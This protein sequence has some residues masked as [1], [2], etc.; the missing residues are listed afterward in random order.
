V[1]G[2]VNFSLPNFFYGG[3]KFRIRVFF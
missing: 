3:E 2:D 1:W